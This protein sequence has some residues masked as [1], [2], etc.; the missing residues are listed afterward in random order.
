M[1]GRLLIV[2][3]DASLRETLA[4]SFELEGYSVES[5]AD[6]REAESQI[7][8]RHF[9]AI[10]LDVMLPYRSGID[11][12]KAAR[13]EGLTTPVLLLTVKNRESEKVEGFD[14]GADDYVTKPFSLVELKARVRALVRR[15]RPQRNDRPEI[16][17]PDRFR[18][19][20]VEIDLEQ[21]VVIR[22]GQKTSISQKEA[23]MLRLLAAAEGRAVSR[24]DFLDQIWGEDI[25]SQRTIDTHVL[26]LRQKL[27]ADSAR[28]ALLLTVHGVG[29]RL[30]QLTVN[31]RA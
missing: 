2:E 16:A 6:G 31:P 17:G 4:D 27:E 24:E 10:V 3:D 7:F 20:S 13:A 28:P 8:S 22:E 14:L 12:L 5:A 19:G 26:H 23:Q 11:L 30:D 18:V 1:L 21:F 9:D 25:V 29:Y 15:S